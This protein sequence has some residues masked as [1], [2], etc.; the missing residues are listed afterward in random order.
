MSEPW[1]LSEAQMRRIEPY[2][3]LGCVGG[4]RWHG[5]KPGQ[6][7]EWHDETRRLAGRR[8]AD[9]IIIKEF[10]EDRERRIDGAGALG[11]G[12]RRHRRLLIR[13]G[14]VGNKPCLDCRGRL[15]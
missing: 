9:Q 10:G 7:A 3:P 2:F 4:Q 14:I 12:E 6:A 13:A 11:E 5:D 8:L 1:L 15:P